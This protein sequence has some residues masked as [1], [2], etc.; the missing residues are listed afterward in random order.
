MKRVAPL[1]AAVLLAAAC[2]I[3]VND[4]D[5]PAG[6]APAGTTWQTTLRTNERALFDGG[7]LEITLREARPGF[8]AVQIHDARGQSVVELR[9]T[10]PAGGVHW[11]P[12][13]IWLATAG[14]GT[15]TITVARE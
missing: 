2:Y 4:N 13:E 1:A 12:Y 6:T 15:A 9:Q 3:A 14:T 5:R 7:A 10:G 11:P 8:A